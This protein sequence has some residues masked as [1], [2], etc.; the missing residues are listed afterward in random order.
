MGYLSIKR[1]N[2]TK[3]P[4]GENCGTLVEAAV[5]RRVLIEGGMKTS[6]I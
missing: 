3:G 6:R 4:S 2:F 5:C 1:G